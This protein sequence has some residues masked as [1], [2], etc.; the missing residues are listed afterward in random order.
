M[1]QEEV[2]ALE[3]VRPDL[4]C[5]FPA[6][7]QH[8]TRLLAF[9][10]CKSEGTGRAQAGPWDVTCGSRIAVP[11]VEGF[12]EEVTSRL[13]PVDKSIVKPW[14]CGEERISRDTF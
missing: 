3:K 12:T 11:G 2:R 9:I 4:F 7:L 1:G 5:N 8:C 10:I 6:R 14:Q 13:R